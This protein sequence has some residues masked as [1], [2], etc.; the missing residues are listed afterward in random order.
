MIIES[1]DTEPIVGSDKPAGQ[2]SGTS[3][4]SPA[5]QIRSTFHAT[6]SKGKTF[7]VSTTADDNVIPFVKVEKV[8]DVLKIGLETRA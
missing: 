7:K 4:D 3:R 6:I 8:K 5:L 1:S 2:N